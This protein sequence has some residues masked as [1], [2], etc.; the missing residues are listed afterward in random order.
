VCWAKDKKE[1]LRTAH[2]HWPNAAIEGELTAE[3]RLPAHFEQTARMISEED[4]GKKV[5]C[6]PDAEEHIEAIKEYSNAGFDCVWVHQVGTDQEGF[7]N[8]YEKEVL[9]KISARKARAGR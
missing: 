9:P 2:K 4:V 3:L 5:V 6:G 7:F 8:F 1:A